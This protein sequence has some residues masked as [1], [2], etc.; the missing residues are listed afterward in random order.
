MW[1]GVAVA[2]EGQEE[3]WLELHGEQKPVVLESGVRTR[4]SICTSDPC[5]IARLILSSAARLASFTVGIWGCV[6]ERVDVVSRLRY[7]TRPAIWNEL[8]LTH[9]SSQFS[10]TLP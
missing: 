4:E 5:Q 3:G 7:L 9:V 8:S 10:Y 1:L 2:T 6:L